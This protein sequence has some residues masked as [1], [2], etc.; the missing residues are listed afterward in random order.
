MSK[1][2]NAIAYLQPIA[3]SAELSGYS[4]A[5]A[6]ALKAL[7]NAEQA[8]MDIERAENVQRAAM[9]TFGEAKQTVK[10]F[11]EI[12]EFMDAFG[13]YF[14]SRDELSHVAEEMADVHNVLDQWALHLGCTEEVD[15]QR[16][17]KLRRLE[18]MIEEAH[19]EKH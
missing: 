5:L 1:Y 4:D 7:R 14:E 12:G 11:S 19:H 6:V 15:R 8:Q 17:Y 2:E 13:K 3:D 16:R 10:L 18:Q 9:K